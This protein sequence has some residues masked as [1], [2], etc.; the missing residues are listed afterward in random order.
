MASAASAHIPVHV[1]TGFL[2]SGKTTLLNRLLR[3]PGLA[4]TAVIV[5]EFGEVGLDHLLVAGGRDNVLLLESGCLCCTLLDSLRETLADLYHRRARGELPPFRRVVVE[6]TGLAD[7]API[8]LTLIRDPIA[9]AWFGLGR[10]AATVDA[11]HGLE[12]L[13][14]YPEARAQVAA[15]DLVLFTKTDLTGGK[16]APGLAA[17]VVRTNAAAA[18][19]DGDRPAAQLR[20]LV[21]GPLVGDLAARVRDAKEHGRGDDM[22]QHSRAIFSVCAE[23]ERPVSWAGLAAWTSLARAS[24]GKRLLRCKGILWI[25]ETGAPV[26]VQGVQTLFAKPTP[27]A[28]AEL[29]DN[30]SRLVCIADGIVP[31]ALR[32]SLKALAIEAGGHAPATIDELASMPDTLGA[33]I[34]CTAP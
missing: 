23:F 24:F 22:H 26:V 32:N 16:A 7:P 4:D 21:F 14:T 30:R 19:A 10:V 12:E 29:P 25:R 8:L 5:N 17:A 31:A 1:L 18:L 6:T 13:A 28:P 11:L 27:I 9:T 3:D 20:E 2:G 33:A 15:A 34:H